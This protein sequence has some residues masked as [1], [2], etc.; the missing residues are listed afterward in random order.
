M[1]DN[2]V[3][4][5]QLFYSA[6]DKLHRVVCAASRVILIAFSGSLLALLSA[7]TTPQQRLDQVATDLGFQRLSLNGDPFQHR[8]YRNAAP[9]STV[10]HVY[11]DGDGS[12]W[13]N[14]RVIA[15][16]TPR[17]PLVLQLM[18]QDS[19][20]SLYLGRP[21]YHGM[22]Q[23]PGCSPWLWTAA[24]YS[25]LVIDSLVAALHTVLREH[26]N[27]AVVLIGYSGGG[28]LAMLLAEHLPQTRLIVT[29][30]ANLDTT[31]WT[32]HHGYSPLLG[33][34]NPANRPPLVTTPQWHLFGEQDDNTPAALSEL[35]IQRQP[36]ARSER[37]AA[38]NHRCCWLDYWPQVLSTLTYGR[39]HCSELE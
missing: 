5:F 13:Q 38:F 14:G 19:Q 22:Q 27:T 10:L 23:A 34:L 30:A 11:L 29:I 21:C 4:L 20:A 31:A 9:I 12:P 15:D 16:P 25:P 36:C 18:A 37:I 6:Y 1:P 8:A 7:C 2:S 33:S 35:L 28:T 3:A 32:E 24:R 17:Q 39:F 26:P